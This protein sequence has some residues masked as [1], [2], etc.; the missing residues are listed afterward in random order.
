MEFWEEKI[1]IWEEVI[2]EDKKWY[3]Q[4]HTY[5]FIL[6]RDHDPIAIQDWCK[7]RL[8]PRHWHY[9]YSFPDP[10]LV[11]P[12]RRGLT[13]GE[14]DVNTITHVPVISFTFESDALQFKMSF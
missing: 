5:H 4:Y 14:I 3:I 9:T 10:R 11:Q 1:P 13:R 2:D 12:E 7:A 8:N 6:P